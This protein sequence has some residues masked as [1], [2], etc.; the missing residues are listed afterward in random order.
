MTQTEFERNV[1]AT[2]AR[3]E[4][5]VEASGADIDFEITAGILELEFNNGSKIIVNRQSA[6]QEIWVAAR[7]G[8]YHYA[9]KDG[10]WR[11]TRD[12][13]ELFASLCHHINEQA[14]ETVNLGG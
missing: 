7:S 5:A 1:D 12:D 11:N 3:I 10:F 14:G 9:W 2:L 13:S 6:N 8:G 4:Q